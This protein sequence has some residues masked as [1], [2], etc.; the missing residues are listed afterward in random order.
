MTITKRRDGKRPLPVRPCECDR[1]RLMQDLDGDVTC[2]KC[3][4]DPVANTTPRPAAVGERSN[5]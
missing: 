3:G 1:P 5:A 2:T 4:R